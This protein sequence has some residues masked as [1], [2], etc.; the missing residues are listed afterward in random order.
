MKGLFLRAASATA[1]LLAFALL[2]CKSRQEA[3][4]NNL[5]DAGYQLTAT[6]WFRAA[7]DDNPVALELF[8]KG[9]MEIGTKTA[10]GNAALHI[11]AAAGAM[12]SGK[13]LLDHKVAIDEPGAGGRTPLMESIVAGKTEMTR[14]LLKQGADRKAKD[15]EGF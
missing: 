1:V 8:L 2:G 13:F 3:S 15:P 10:D 11:A 5:G 6:D 12:K 9:G 7:A 4:S 14:W